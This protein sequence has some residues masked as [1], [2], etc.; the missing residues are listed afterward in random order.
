MNKSEINELRGRLASDKNNITVIRGCYVNDEK[1]IIS[2]FASAPY[3]LPE[4]EKTKYFDIFKHILSGVQGKNLIDVNFTPEQVMRSEAHSLL[5]TLRDTA[6]KDD[7]MAQAFFERVIENTALEGRSLILLTQDSYQSI[8][9]K[10]DGG[11]AA[12][13]EGYS[14]IVCAV[15]PV[16]K[17]KPALSYFSEDHEFH[18]RDED[19]VVASPEM[20]FLFPAFDDFSANIYGALYHTRTDEDA[21]EDFYAAAFDAPMDMPAA[22]QRETFNAVLTETLRERC[23]FEV[24]Q[25]LHDKVSIMV[26]ERKSDKTAEPP[27][28][29]KREV[30]QVL[31]E[32][33]VPKER[34]D[35]F[36][37]RYD[38]E[39]GERAALGAQNIVDVKKFEMRTEN[40]VIQ[41][42]PDRSDLIE[43][44]VIDGV[45]YILVRATDE[46]RVN[47]MKITIG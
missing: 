14:Y 47:G 29:T 27:V 5:M 32:C 17:T 34:V 10:D 8:R 43:T 41:V 25:A 16:K 28:L 23:P 18:S 36:E 1:Q 3:L 4:G 11:D 33:G 15:C 9:R 46:V 6:L 38:E 19:W 45:P 20:G 42:N 40:V 35:T 13:R 12:P 24:A 26:E 39:L 2:T 21:H 37:K 30:S 31:S 22:E 44:R 7:D